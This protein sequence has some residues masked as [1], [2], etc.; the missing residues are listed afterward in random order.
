MA[1]TK[2]PVG[3]LWIQVRQLPAGER[4]SLATRI[5]RSLE[6]DAGD[7]R[8][9][10]RTLADLVGIMASDQ[11]PPTDAEVDQILEEE[12]ERRFR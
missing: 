10:K 11:P 12:R 5:L 4:L 3:E 9:P 6:Q 2:V 8:P 7:E 1:T